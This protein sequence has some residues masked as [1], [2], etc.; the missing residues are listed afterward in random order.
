MAWTARS[1]G[2]GG[3][4]RRDRLEMVSLSRSRISRRRPLRRKDRLVARLIVLAEDRGL[5]DTFTL[6]HDDFGVYRMKRRQTFRLW[7]PKI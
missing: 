2:S 7:P 1:I 5:R 3:R 4:G 6:E